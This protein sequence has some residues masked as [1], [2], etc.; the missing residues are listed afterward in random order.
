MAHAAYVLLAFQERELTDV[1]WG[2]LP[3]NGSRFEEISRAIVALSL[4]YF[5]AVLAWQL[6]IPRFQGRG[7]LRDSD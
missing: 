5:V 7:A 1:H 2:S 6:V 3:N 4:W